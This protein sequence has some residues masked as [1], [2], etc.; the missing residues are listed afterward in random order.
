MNQEIQE[1]RCMSQHFYQTVHGIMKFDERLI[2]FRA[3]LSSWS[4]YRGC[5]A[6]P[7]RQKP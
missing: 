3:R 7:L 4:T 6:N 2:A 5:A 1:L